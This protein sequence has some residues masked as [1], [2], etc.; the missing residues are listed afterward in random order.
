MLLQLSSDSIEFLCVVHASREG[1][2]SPEGLYLVEGN[3]PVDVRRLARAP[4]GR[5]VVVV[6]LHVRD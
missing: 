5:I 3:Q 4:Q 1:F 6:E 2:V